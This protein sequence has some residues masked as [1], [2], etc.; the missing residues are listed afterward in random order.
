MSGY[1]VMETLCQGKAGPEANEDRLVIL[2]HIVA[3]VDGTTSSSAFNGVA[4]GVIAAD[5]VVRAMR[6]L[7]A[8]WTFRELVDRATDELSSLLQPQASNGASPSAYL[9]AWHP[10]RDE[11]YRLG[12]S[13]ARLGDRVLIGEKA[14]DALGSAF[15]NACLQGR[16]R[17]GLTS[18]EEA[19]SSH[20]LEDAQGPL[21]KV[22]HAF[23]NRDTGHPL[24]Y[25]AIDGT[26]VP[27]RFLEIHSTRGV[28]EVVLCS[29]GFV[30][31]APTLAGAVAELAR[32]RE[33]DPLLTFMVEGSRAFPP[34]RELFD[35]ATYVRLRVE[36]AN[37]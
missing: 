3:V 25:G 33:I 5:A 35:D 15:R 8:N 2:P 20:V 14:I 28:E 6:D 29:D 1:E 32:L 37:R 13:H 19:R 12:D 23:Q 21:I 18:I 7:R 11:L 31:P 17:L 9:I 4:G 16:L 36:R 27:N 34:G 24:E 22:Q 30:S 10:A 26:P